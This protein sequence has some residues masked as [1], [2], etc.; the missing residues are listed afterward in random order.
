[1]RAAIRGLVIAALFA[2]PAAA[3]RELPAIGD[4]A[5]QVFSPR[6][7]AAIGRQMMARARAL[8]DLN[9]DPQIAE[10]VD[11]VGQR[12]TSH[13]SDGPEDG[14]EFF[15]VH[16][17]SINAFAA[18]GGYIGINSGLI[19]QAENEAQL[20]AVLAHEIA[21]VNQRHIARAYAAN[22]RSSYG[23]LAA[24]LAGLILSSQDPQA[25]QAAITTGI[26]AEQQRRINYTRSNEYEADRIGIGLLTEAGY[27]PDGMSGMF[28]LLSRASSGA[29]ATPEFLRTHPLSSNRIAEARGRAARID[30]EGKLRDTLAFHQMRARLAVLES[31][32]PQVL[33]QRWRAEQPSGEG[34]AATAHAYGLALLEIELGDA[35][36]AI[37]RLQNLRTDAPDDL[38][39]GLAL[40]EA[41]READRGDDAL[42]AWGEIHTL[43]PSAYPV[44]AAGADLHVEFHRA[45]EAVELVTDFVRRSDDPPA[46]AWRDL[47]RAAQAADRPTRSHEALA[48]FYARTDRYDRA[49]KQLELALNAAE[50]GSSDTLRLEARMEQVRELQRRRI[51][52]SPA[53]GG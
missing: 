18:P 26:A 12:L 14:F 22:Q 11:R 45:S 24:V 6:E 10:Y 17:P 47:A 39:Y 34:H 50:S 21:H 13:V 37:E 41:F 8:L 43:H 51:A 1:M 38:H 27:H 32:E 3:E 48:E 29:G 40:V 31:D 28:D 46:E 15:V 25:G 53:S 33:Y 4:P 44:I 2:A 20:A 23:T 36:A 5:D 42:A 7:E 52:A 35:A 19:L 49:L 16:A 30:T 9:S